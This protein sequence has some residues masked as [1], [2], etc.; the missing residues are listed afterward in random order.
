MLDSMVLDVLLEEDVLLDV[1]RKA[2]V[3]GDCEVL[4]THIQVDE[5]ALTPE[6]DKR[7]RLIPD[8]PSLRPAEAA[9]RPNQVPI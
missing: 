9:Q 5:I 6:I 1:L 8:P 3:A 4:V 7:Q 2:V